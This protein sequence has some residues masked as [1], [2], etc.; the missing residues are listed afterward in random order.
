M[1]ASAELFF[2]PNPPTE[3]GE[4]PI[5]SPSDDTLQF[6]DFVR[7]KSFVLPIDPATGPVDESRPA[8]CFDTEVSLTMHAFVK[9]KPQTAVGLYHQGVALLDCTTFQAKVLK[10]IIP[11]SK[12]EQKRLNDGAVDCKGRLWGGELDIVPVFTK[13]EEAKRGIFV[14]SA[15][16][17][18]Q[19]NLWRYDPDGSLHLMDKGF[20]CANGLCW[21]PDNT[22]MYV[23]DTLCGKTY[24][25]DFDAEAGTI[26]NKR[27]LRDHKPPDCVDGAVVDSAGNI[28]IAL[29]AAGKAIRVDPTGNISKEVSIPTKGVTC[30][31][32]SKDGRTLFFTS[33]HGAGGDGAG[34]VYKYDLTDEDPTGLVKKEFL[35]GSQL[36]L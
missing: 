18:G 16:E 17:S 19:G 30:P 25:Y 36:S 20:L 21:S 10:Q 1:V 4:G 22:V 2:K 31:T 6:H 5:Y 28:W 15:P 14:F 33:A 35:L 32:W 24:A 34:D 13:V 3:I 12:K 29:Y 9:G 23:N 26:N 27:T 7:S 8:K 11:D